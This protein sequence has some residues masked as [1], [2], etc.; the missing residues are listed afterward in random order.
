M[1][2]SLYTELVNA[3]KWH[4][5]SPGKNKSGCLEKLTT[6]PETWRLKSPQMQEMGKS[7]KAATGL[8]KGTRMD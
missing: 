7:T 3:S 5:T 8:S 1:L 6:R 2:K 4:A